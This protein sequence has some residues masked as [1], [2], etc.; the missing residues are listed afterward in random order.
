MFAWVYGSGC[1]FTMTRNNM[2]P[3]GA[4]IGCICFGCLTTL[5]LMQT[6]FLVAKMDKVVNWGYKEVLIPTFALYI[7]GGCCALVCI[8]AY[9]IQRHNRKRRKRRKRTKRTKR[10]KRTKRTKRWKSEGPIHTS[11]LYAVCVC[12]GL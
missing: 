10:R 12:Y 3:G 4:L 7:F 11:T 9:L 1:Y 6:V 8:V 5:I 2:N